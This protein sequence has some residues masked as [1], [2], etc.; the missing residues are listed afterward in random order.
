VAA[1]VYSYI[2]LV[3]A[4]QQLANRLYDSSQQFWSSAELGVYVREAL[5]TFNALTGYWRGDFLFSSQIGVPWYDMTNLAQMPNTL[6]P[7]TLLDTNLYT[8]IQYALL[9]PAT[10][11]NPW[12]GVSSQFSANDLINAVQRRR[13]E[14]ISNSGCTMTRRLVPAVNGRIVLPDTVIDIR[15]MAYLPAQGPPSVVWADDTWSEQSFNRNYTL[16]PPGTPSVYL[17]SAQ[18]PISFDVDCPPGAAGQYELITVEAGPAL[19][20]GTPQTLS[21]PDD[22]VHLIKWGALADLLSRDTNA[23]DDQRAAYCEARY[24]M[25]LKALEDA[26]AL[27]AMRIGNVPLEVDSVRSADLYNTSWEGQ[28][29]ALPTAALHMGLNLIALAP[30]PDKGLS[31]YGAGAYGAGAYSSSVPYSLMATVVENAPVPILNGDPIQVGRDDLD[32]IIDYAQHLALFK[33]GGAEFARTMPL[34]KRFLTQASIYGLKLSELGEFTQ[35]L[36]GLGAREAQQNPIKA[37][38]PV[39]ADLG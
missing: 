17:L 23:R 25:G 6:R 35:P 14:L 3:T 29:P 10:G 30:M 22:W 34:L 13:D 26:P 32:V 1:P 9:E 16:A 33:T 19:V 2:D 39:G 27:L 24:R 8:D 11:V 21:V 15:R 20:A 38:E 31:V 37:P 4:K 7:Y 5:R 12:T 18:P 28:T 36:Y